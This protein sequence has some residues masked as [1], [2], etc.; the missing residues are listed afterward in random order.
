MELRLTL[1]R[2][3][4]ILGDATQIQEHTD[5]VKEI[6]YIFQINGFLLEFSV[7]MIKMD[8]LE[9]SLKTQKDTLLKEIT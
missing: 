5:K 7:T 2:K 3:M 9:L 8:S 6:Y 4:L 1:G